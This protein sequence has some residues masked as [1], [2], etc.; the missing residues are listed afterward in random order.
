MKAYELQ[1]IFKFNS[2]SVDLTT[3]GIEIGL[4]LTLVKIVGD[5]RLF[6]G[7]IFA[8]YSENGNNTTKMHEWEEHFG[9][10]KTQIRFSNNQF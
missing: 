9:R 8:D 1:W 5:K 7:V 3:Y 6:D 10:Y 4:S 2:L